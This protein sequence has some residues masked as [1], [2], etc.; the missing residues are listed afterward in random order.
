MIWALVLAAGE[1]KRMGRPKLLLPFRKKTIIETVIENVIHS[2]VKKASVVL[3]ADKEDIEKK[4]QGFPVEITVNPHFSKGMLSSIQ[5][6]IRNLPEDTRAVLIVLGDQPAI[7]SSV[8]DKIVDSFVQT[9]KGIILPVYEKER[10]HPVLIDMKYRTEVEN[11]S[12]EI[13]LRG[14]VYSHPDDILEIRVE[15]PAVLRDIDDMEDY[16]RELK[17]RG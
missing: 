7:S 8:I 13:G 5:W 3:G 1:S 16:R 14:V 10:G 9:G 15:T 12:P 4:I 11:L 2:K 6:G 17:N